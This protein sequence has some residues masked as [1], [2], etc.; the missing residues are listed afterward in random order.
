MYDL[1]V[2][3]F[4]LPTPDLQIL[5]KVPVELAAIRAL[6]L[7]AAV[8]VALLAG[9]FVLTEIGVVGVIFTLVW[10]YLFYLRR[11]VAKR[12]A[13]GRLPSQQYEGETSQF[14]QPAGQNVQLTVQSDPM[15]TG[16][17]QMLLQAS[18][19]GQSFAVPFN[20][21]TE[22]DY[23][24]GLGLTQAKDYAQLTFRVD[25][26]SI[27]TVFDGYNPTVTTSHQTLGGVHL[28]AGAHQLTIVTYG[29]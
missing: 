12:M 27:G 16:G 13:E 25:G 21:N 26:N 2:K 18:L 28:T 1:E 9:F 20:V 15:W 14:T 8:Q 23:T 22:A 3:R 5:L 7:V 24:L 11:D 4:A 6:W 29:A 10:G 17:R 19:V